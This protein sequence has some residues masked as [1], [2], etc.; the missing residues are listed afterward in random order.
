MNAPSRKSVVI[1]PKDESRIFQ[2]LEKWASGRDFVAV[3]TKAFVYLLR[4]GAVRSKMAVNLNVEEVVSDPAASRIRIV[5]EVTQRPCEA[6]RYKGRQFSLS[7]RTRAALLLYVRAIREGGWLPAKS[8][9]EGPLF[10]TTHHYGDGKR[11]SQRTAVQA[12]RT[13]LEHAQME[14]EYQLDDLVFSGRI[15]FLKA[16]GGNMEMLSEHASISQQWTDHYRSHVRPSKSSA[17]DVL[18]KL[19]KRS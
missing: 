18:T 16:A 17:R 12:W 3:R 11:M 9:L 2:A 1:P 6:N 8:Q 4:D 14:T 19:Y 5:T 10:I 15:A 7:D 13:L